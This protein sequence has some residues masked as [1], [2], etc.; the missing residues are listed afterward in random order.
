MQRKVGKYLH[1][2]VQA[3]QAVQQFVAARS[4]P[5][6]R[7]DLQLRSAVERQFEIIGEALNQALRL[8]PEREVPVT[9]ARRIIAFR[10]ILAHQYSVVRD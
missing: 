2:V 10:N 1:D 7:D 4:L 3:G 8:A 5:D 9:C 6:Y